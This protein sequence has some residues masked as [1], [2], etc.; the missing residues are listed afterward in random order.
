MATQ[1][2]KLCGIANVVR[3]KPALRWL[4]VTLKFLGAE[5]YVLGTKHAELSLTNKVGGFGIMF[6][7]D[8]AMP[9]AWLLGKHNAKGLLVDVAIHF[10]AG[11][12]LP[13]LS[14]ASLCPGRYPRVLRI[15][16]TIHV[17]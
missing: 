10:E 5:N 3:P 7:E 8:I 17:C 1:L 14:L 9:D 13:C 2:E 4:P 15:G 12:T 11:T 6:K 16:G